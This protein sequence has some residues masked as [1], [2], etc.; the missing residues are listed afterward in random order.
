MLRA[1]LR[2]AGL[3]RGLDAETARLQQILRGDYLHHPA[4]VEEAFGQQ[5]LALLRQLDTAC[6]NAEDLADAA[7]ERFARHPDAAIITSMPG[8]AELTGARVLAEIGDDR[9]RFA[10]ARGLEAYAGSAP[11]TRA[12]GKPPPSCIGGNQRLTSVGYV[13]AFAALT[14]SPGTRAH[15]DRRKNAGDRHVA[16]HATCSTD[17]WAACTTAC[18]PARPTT[19][20]SPY[21]PPQTPPTLLP[22]D[23]IRAWD[24]FIE[25][26]GQ[27]FESPQLHSCIGVMFTVFAQL[28]RCLLRSI[29]IF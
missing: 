17:S 3:Q 7:T 11:V 18:T 28:C 29:S 5:A 2:R 21:P 12:S 1:L 10:D 4:L 25:L 27:G 16:A 13:W 22:L 20:P 24:V 6:A 19:R 14:A 15:Y 8:L 23:T 9:D 26:R